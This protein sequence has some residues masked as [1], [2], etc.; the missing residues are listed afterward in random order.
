MTT[1][2]DV[3]DEAQLFL[4]PG[5]PRRAD[6][7]RDPNPFYDRL[8]SA[9]PVLQ[10]PD[11]RWVISGYDEAY[12]MLRDRSLSSHIH[13][14]EA[15][16]SLAHRVFMGSL[17]FKDP[18]EHTRLRR[19]V[20][21]LFTPKAMTGWREAIAATARELLAEVR[22]LETFDFTTGPS[23][24][25]PVFVI[26]RLMGLPPEDFQQFRNWPEALIFLDENPSATGS[27]LDH[28]NGIAQVALDYFTDVIEQRRRRPGDDLISRLILADDGPSALTDE[29]IVAMCVILH[30]GGHHTTSTLLDNGL[31][32][33]TREPAQAAAL[34]ANPDLAGNAVEEMLRYEPP[35]ATAI[36]RHTTSEI[37]AGG[38]TVPA[39]QTVLALLGAA[40]RD[41]RVSDDPHRFNITRP[42]PKHLAFA[43]GS[44]S[45]I[46]LN[47]ARMEAIE[48][49]RILVT[50]L[51]PL[52]LAI[53]HEEVQWTDSYMHRG[54][55]SLPVRW[56]S[57]R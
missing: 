39:G 35:V 4:S 26:A 25:L 9:A 22:E 15:Q 31:F 46:G 27:E 54:P 51:P 43:T 56:T 11:G 45:C 47:V 13:V 50:E 28:V 42:E 29:E 16:Q 12:A 32:H 53:P 21:T 38:Q 52:E 49:L 2:T 57:T 23:Y 17:L 34:R 20:S 5:D 44:H 33:L 18:P 19:T 30:I 40:G 36:A 37:V 6:M 1:V 24:H 48:F 3:T 55:T 10:V 8:R 7:V 41:P 14:D